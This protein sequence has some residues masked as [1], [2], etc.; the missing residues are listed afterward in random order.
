M[1]VAAFV[2]I[3][4]TKTIPRIFGFDAGVKD[5]QAT[6]MGL[7]AGTRLGAALGRGTKGLAN[8]IGNSM[9][10]NADKLG[11]WNENRQEAGGIGNHLQNGMQDKMNS[12]KHPLQTAQNAMRSSDLAHSF[13]Q[14]GFQQGQ[15]NDLAME[16]GA[17]KTNAGKALQLN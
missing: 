13:A 7:Y 8:G 9:D 12:F 5:G 11:K 1:I 17:T 2:V 6:L 10:Y 3:D 16:T 15:L 4:G 14:G